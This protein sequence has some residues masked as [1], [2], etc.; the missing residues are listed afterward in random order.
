MASGRITVARSPSLLHVAH[1]EKPRHP[2]VAGARPQLVR[3]RDLREPALAEHRHP[4]AQRERLA[5]VVGDVHDRQAEPLEER[6]Q[7]GLQTVPQ[8]AVEGAQRLVEEEYGRAWSERAGEGDPLCLSAGERRD[9]AAPRAGETRRARVPRP[10]GS[11]SRR[12]KPP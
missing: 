2:V 8:G 10:R 4:V 9:V 11:L 1:A 6:R 5:D 7:V 3:S 12:P